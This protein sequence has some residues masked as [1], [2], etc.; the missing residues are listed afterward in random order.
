MSLRKPPLWASVFTVLGVLILC[1]L[2]VWQ[3]KRLH[4]KETLL[5]K[6]DAVEQIDALANPLTLEDL[7]A[8]AGRHEPYLR[9]N[10]RGR[11]RAE[12][13]LR[14]SPQPLDGK[15]GN[16]LYMPLQLETGGYVLVNRGWVP[17]GPLDIETPDQLVTVAGLF[18]EPAKGN[19]FTPPNIP[20]QRAWYRMDLAQIAAVQGLDQLAPYVLYAESAVDE[21]VLPKP[22]DIRIAIN[23][24][25]L[26][27]AIFWFA[28]AGVLIVIYVL[29]FI[30]RERKAV[31][32]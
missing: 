9:G 15:P 18:K 8:A 10:V 31:Q 27:Y 28:M 1:S 20:A 26:A 24:N 23:N 14:S 19:I 25:H 4:W 17:A 21:D 12:K 16:H 29:R 22:V 32:P 13:Y 5:Q 11:Y 7:T 3:I 30:V 6:I 2:G